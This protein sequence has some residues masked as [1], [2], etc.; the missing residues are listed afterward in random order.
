M[1]GN[2]SIA[3]GLL[4]K[5]E[6]QEVTSDSFIGSYAVVATPNFASVPL[7]RKEKL[8]VITPTTSQEPSLI[9]QV[10]RRNGL[11]DSR[12]NNFHTEKDTQQLLRQIEQV[13]DHINVKSSY[14]I[15]GYGHC[16]V[17]SLKEKQNEQHLLNFLKKMNFKLRH[18]H[19]LAEKWHRNTLND[20]RS[21]ILHDNELL[22]AWN[23]LLQQINLTSGRDALHQQTKELFR[24]ICEKFCKRR[25]ITFLAIDY[26][27]TKNCHTPNATR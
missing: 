26:L 2:S 17:S 27:K 10:N 15:I 12:V 7:K 11:N 21:K 25:C 3:T 8:S 20:A 13:F 22:S 24:T 4:V 1:E 19:F 6:K 18:E 9:Q 16:L 23:T 5:A 14:T